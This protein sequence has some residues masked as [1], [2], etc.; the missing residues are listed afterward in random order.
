MSTIRNRCLENSV[1]TPVPAA[2]AP[3]VIQLQGDAGERGEG[4]RR[5]GHMRGV[6]IGGGK[7]GFSRRIDGDGDDGD[8]DDC[9]VPSA[10][11]AARS[12]LSMDDSADSVRDQH[13][14]YT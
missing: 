11:R 5:A 10:G 8:D 1:L 3:I 4:R 6:H 13:N 12:P 14:T 9:R 7:E 2:L